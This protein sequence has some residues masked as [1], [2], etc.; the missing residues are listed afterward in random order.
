MSFATALSFIVIVSVLS[1][2]GYIAGT[3]VSDDVY[4]LSRMLYR[5]FTDYPFVLKPEVP[6]ARVSF[7]YLNDYN[8]EGW[9]RE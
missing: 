9:E 2:L 8:P 5:Y 6:V 1:T 3:L 4:H 7:T